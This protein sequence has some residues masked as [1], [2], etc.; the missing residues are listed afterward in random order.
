MSRPRFRSG[1]FGKMLLMVGLSALIPLIAVIA[2]A[3]VDAYR[4]V[5][6]ESLSYAEEQG[7]HFADLIG[8]E[9]TVRLSAVRSMAAMEESYRDI[10]ASVRRTVLSAQVRAILE[11]NPDIL[12]A[13]SQWEP[14][15]IGD[16]PATY[17]G[18]LLT[19][20]RGAFNVLWYRMGGKLL[21]GAIGIG[22]EN[23]DFFTIPKRR[24]A[25][26]LIA[27]YYYSYEGKVNNRVLET[28]ICVPIIVDGAFKGVAGFDIALASSQ[29]LVSGIK[30]LQHGYAGMLANNGMRIAHPVPSLIGGVYGE[31]LPPARQKAI[32]AD[33]AAGKTFVVDKKDLVDGKMSRQ[34]F[35]PLHVGDTGDPWYL[36]ATVP[37]SDITTAADRLVLT[38]VTMGTIAA[39]I[40]FMAIFFAARSLSRPIRDLMGGAALLASGDL[41]VRVTPSGPVEIVRLADSFNAMA[42]KLAALVGQYEVSNQA[43]SERNAEL[44]TAQD[45]LGILNAELEQKVRD[46]TFALTEANASLV[47]SNGSLETALENLRTAQ[48]QVVASEKMAVLGQLMANIAHELNTPLGAIR[49][50]AT[51]LAQTSSGN[52]PELFSFIASL[53]AEDLAA[54]LSLTRL[55]REN[56]S[57]FLETDHRRERRALASRFRSAGYADPEMLA[58][59]VETIGAFGLEDE[60]GALISR[61]RADIIHTAANLAAV[62]RAEVIIL[63]AADKAARTVSALVDYSRSEEVEKPQ[64]VEPVAEIRTLLVLYYNRIKTGVTVETRFDCMDAVWGHRERLNQVWVNL[65]NNALQAMEYRGKL[66]LETRRVGD[67]IAISVTDSG[68]GIPEAIRSSIFKPFFTTKKQGEGTGLGLDICR[69]IVELHEGTIEFESRPGRTTFTVFLRTAGPITIARDH[70]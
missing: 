63:T 17:R 69:K 41:S 22:D 33:M 40:V 46:R 64:L 23:G 11:R 16:D 15:A 14:G 43:L 36:V 47:R 39:L 32:L 38:L 45:S 28:T 18:S 56:A 51:Y 9:L 34:F 1:L 2:I 61:G 67:R 30:L 5:S 52:G 66:E 62:S 65:I 57:S 37:F 48:D 49:S 20:S 53:S 6:R 10:P 44:K 8:E 26:T 42:E 13:W 58:D 31:D 50:S 35:A 54:F 12:A 29:R 19:T 25:E 70:D 24:M 27:P 68:P 60:I 3:T 59:E 55:G 7:R 4:I 21:L